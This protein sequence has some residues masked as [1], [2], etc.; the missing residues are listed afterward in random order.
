MGRQNQMKDEERWK[1]NNT[2]MKKKQINKNTWQMSIWIKLKRRDITNMKPNDKRQLNNIEK[3]W[4]ILT[5]WPRNDFFPSSF[6]VRFHLNLLTEIA[7]TG[8][9]SAK[10]QQYNCDSSTSTV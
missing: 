5:F 4:Y 2:E 8:Q 10:Q 9:K 1:N 3:R 7:W 6:A